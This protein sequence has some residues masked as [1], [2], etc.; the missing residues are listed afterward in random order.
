MLN[1]NKRFIDDDAEEQE[2][3]RVLGLDLTVQQSEEVMYYVMK[4]SRMLKKRVALT[5]CA[6]LV[7]GCI[8]FTAVPWVI[9]ST[10]FESIPVIVILCGVLV[11][12]FGIFS[13]IKRYAVIVLLY[14][15]INTLVCSAVIVGL[16]VLCF[17]NFSAFGWQCQDL[18]LFQTDCWYSHSFGPVLYLLTSILPRIIIMLVS[19]INGI[20]FSVDYC[21]SG[22]S[23][24]AEEKEYIPVY[25]LDQT[26]LDIQNAN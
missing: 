16:V 9:T 2:R 7:L 22:E 24:N 14:V 23:F 5:V 25:H 13:A 18:Q 15:I 20:T 12:L 19:L 21:Q 17:M 11:F 4:K 26:S 3:E 1:S 8:L 10:Q 6:F